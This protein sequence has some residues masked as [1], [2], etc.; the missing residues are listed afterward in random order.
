[1]I[2]RWKEALQNKQF[3]LELP[4]FSIICFIMLYFSPEWMTI[5]ENQKGNLLYDPILDALPAIDYSTIIMSLIYSSLFLSLGLVLTQPMRFML[6]VK[7]FYIV[8]TL[9][10]LLIYFIPL[11]PHPEILLLKD[12]FLAMIVYDSL[13]ITKDLFFSG[14]MSTM[15]M[16]CIFMPYKPLKY[17]LFVAAFSLG[18]LLMIQHV[19]YS[20]DIFAAVI[21]SWGGYR[22]AQLNWLVKPFMQNSQTEFNPTKK[23]QNKMS[24]TESRKETVAV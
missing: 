16:A 17:A 24:M 13:P 23:Y 19:H 5:V 14:H 12:P 6:A 22:I 8:V 18:I 11:E 15:F 1:M 20:Y 9:R 2:K 10:Y 4:T 21:I 7:T 3:L